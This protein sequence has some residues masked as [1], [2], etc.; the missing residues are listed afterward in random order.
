M[1]DQQ[2]RRSRP[3]G[4]VQPP[5]AGGGVPGAD[6]RQLDRGIH[7]RGDRLGCRARPAAALHAR[8]GPRPPGGREPTR[9]RR[10]RPRACA[11]RGGG[12][13]VATGAKGEWV[14]A[15][16]QSA[17]LVLAGPR[18]GKTSC[19]DDHRAAPRPVRTVLP[20]RQERGMVNAPRARAPAR[21]DRPARPWRSPRDDRR[22]MSA[23][24]HEPLPPAPFVRDARQ[25]CFGP[26]ATD[27]E[28]RRTQ[29]RGHLPSA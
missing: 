27:F 25:P 2:S 22:A 6:S 15:P 1:L 20:A 4:L 8:G 10:S 14:A 21:P 5:L 29:P 24:S 9:P 26:V 18:A 28:G 23:L 19:A 13:Y 16:P 17:V 12:A 3:G 7:A 11:A